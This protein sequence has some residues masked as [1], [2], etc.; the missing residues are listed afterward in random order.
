[1]GNQTQVKLLIDKEAVITRLRESQQAFVNTLS[2][3]G[4]DVSSIVIQ[5]DE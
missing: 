4:H 2:A 5:K 1:V 3:L